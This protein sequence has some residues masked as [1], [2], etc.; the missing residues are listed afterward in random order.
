MRPEAPSGQADVQGIERLVAGILQ[1]I[2]G[3]NANLR[4]RLR[5]KIDANFLLLDHIGGPK[6]RSATRKPAR[7]ASGKSEQ[8][9]SRKRS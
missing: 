4:L 6:G 7:G 1:A 3:G 8:V 5:R 2:F 9:S